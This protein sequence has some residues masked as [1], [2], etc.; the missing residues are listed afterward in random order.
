[1]RGRFTRFTSMAVA[2]LALALLAGCTSGGQP[3]EADPEATA[4][5]TPAAEQPA[6]LDRAYLDAA[7]FGAAYDPPFEVFYP[8]YLPD[9]FTLAEAVWADPDDPGDRAPGLYVT[10]ERETDRIGVGVAI[11]DIGEAEPVATLPWGG[12]GEVP[13]YPDAWDDS[14]IALY[15]SSSEYTPVVRTID[16]PLGEFTAL[17]GAMTRVEP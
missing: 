15:P 3:A 8:A 2:L 10:Y 13:V 5:P 1:M 16:V 12:T 17:L 9:G 11:G 14:F 4:A 6:D 7:A